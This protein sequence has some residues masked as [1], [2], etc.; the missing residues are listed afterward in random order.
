MNRFIRKGMAIFLSGCVF[1]LMVS[2]TSA[3]ETEVTVSVPKQHEVVIDSKDG[4]VVVNQSVVDTKF[5][6]DRH[7]EVTYW[8]LPDAGKEIQTVVYDGKDV[9]DQVVDHEYTAPKLVRNASLTVT[10]GD[11]EAPDENTY[12]I[13]GSITGTDQTP[14]N[15]SL[16]IG[17][18]KT[19]VSKDG[20]FIFP[21]ISSG[22]HTMVLMDQ[23][24]NILAHGI[25]NIEKAQDNDLQTVTSE[26]GNI[27]IIPSLKTENITLQILLEKGHLVLSGAADS[28]PEYI[29]NIPEKVTIGNTGSEAEITAYS[30]KNMLEGDSLNVSISGLDEEGNAVL[31][32][33]YATDTLLVPVQDAQGN[34]I[35]NNDVIASFKNNGLTAAEGGKIVFGALTGEKKAG[36]YTGKLTFTFSYER[37]LEEGTE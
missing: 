20:S 32:R 28:T 11:I 25:L 9:T 17:G 18:K 27:S 33:Q 14:N 6:A 29:I 26:D 22:L 31:I 37:I 3:E 19:T 1:A 7:S 2:P 30:I 5:Q 23:N 4:R 10:Y 16:E 8:I 24:E 36:S 13:N 12:I 21:N 34:P 35:S 15:L